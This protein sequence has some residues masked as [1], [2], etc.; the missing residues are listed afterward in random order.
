MSVR[1]S[2]F[3]AS[4]VFLTVGCTKGGNQNVSIKTDEQK[5]SYA[6]GQQIGSGLKAQNI[7]VDL[8]VLAASIGDAV[9]GAPSRLQPQEMQEAMMRMQQQMQAK[10]SGVGKENKEKA[11]KF[12]AE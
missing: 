5:V 10:Q 2:C 12:L 9:N 3:V 6:I 7:K 8:E 1:F 4:A 11:D